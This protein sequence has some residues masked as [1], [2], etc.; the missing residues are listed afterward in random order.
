MKFLTTIKHTGTTYFEKGFKAH[1]KDFDLKHI[2]QEVLDSIKPEWELYTTY[3]DPYRVAASW[4][5]RHMF[6]EPKNIE[7]WRESWRCYQKLL[8]LN[9]VILDFTKGQVFEGID[10]GDKPLNKFNDAYELHK[11]LDFCEY[12]KIYKF[13]PKEHIDYAIECCGDLYKETA[14]NEKWRKNLLKAALLDKA[15]KM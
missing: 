15:M 14:N 7:Y 5:N 3:R 1:C 2:N 9:P 8:E 13:L 4:A 12:D 11:A 6:N 10:F